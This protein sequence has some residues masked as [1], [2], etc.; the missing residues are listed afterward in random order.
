M[1]WNNRYDMTILWKPY[2][3]YRNAMG[4][5]ITIVAQVGLWLQYL[6]IVYDSIKGLLG[7]PNQ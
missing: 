6:Y 5:N 2:G 3:F 7:I 1:D 4:Y